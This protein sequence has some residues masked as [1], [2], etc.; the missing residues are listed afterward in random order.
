V[1]PAAL[2]LPVAVT[3]LDYGRL[4]EAR[5]D[6]RAK[7]TRP[8]QA[9]PW[10]PNTHQRRLWAPVLTGAAVL[11]MALAHAAS[12]SRGG[13]AALLLGL[14]V[15]TAGIARGLR[16]E[17]EPRRARRWRAAALVL[18]AASAAAVA[19]WFAADGTP[20]RAFADV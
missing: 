16:R 3:R 10:A 6:A 13:T 1:D 20:A 15:A 5:D 11:L 18:A 7:G 2:A 19:L 4:R 14:A 17:S 8:R 9:L 12:G